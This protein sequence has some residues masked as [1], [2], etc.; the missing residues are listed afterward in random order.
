MFKP[1]RGSWRIAK[2]KADAKADKADRDVK[3][4]VKRLD[5]GRCRWPEKHRCRGGLE[6]AHLKDASL[7][8]TM[9]PNN[10]IS[11]CAW[12]HRLGP[13]TQQYEQLDIRPLSAKLGTRGPCSFWR[14]KWSETRKGEF[15]WVL[16]AKESAVG[17]VE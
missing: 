11:L 6:A 10:L 13:E 2:E 17:V 8:G 7:G 9:T 4:E 16:V 1:P 15:R 3:A 5:G 12:M 14:K